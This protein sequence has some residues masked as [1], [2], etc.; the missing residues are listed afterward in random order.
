MYGFYVIMIATGIF[1]IILLIYIRT[2]QTSSKFVSN[3]FQF[4]GPA[5]LGRVLSEEVD[6]GGYRIPAKVHDD[7]YI[8]P[9]LPHPPPHP[10]PPELHLFIVA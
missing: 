8:F 10:P 9:P 3:R 2:Y 4:I 6:I 1:I 7:T 5:V